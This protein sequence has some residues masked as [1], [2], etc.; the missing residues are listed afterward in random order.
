MAG[1]ETYLK[2]EN[3]QRG[4]SF[5]IRGAYNKISSLKA[6]VRKRGVVAA[7]AGNH[8]QGVALAANKYGIPA[9]V[10]MPEHAPISKQSAVTGYGADRFY[11]VRNRMSAQM[12]IGYT[13]ID[14]T[15]ETHGDTHNKE[16]IGKLQ[17][18]GYKVTRL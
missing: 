17:S 2:L 1:V 5:K 12:E 11:R 4:G 13:G 18:K 10:V 7:S 14:V 8:A 6:S 16:I 9:T 3:L 15:L